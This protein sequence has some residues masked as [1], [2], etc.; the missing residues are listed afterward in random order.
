MRG[1]GRAPQSTRTRREKRAVPWGRVRTDATDAY[2]PL[3]AGANLFGGAHD[4]GTER[5]KT[6]MRSLSGLV[7]QHQGPATKRGF[8]LHDSYESQPLE[9]SGKELGGDGDK[10]RDRYDG[11][12][13]IE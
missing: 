11:E 7:L 4:G 9:P 6:R 5:V 1:G 3:L 8:H 12:T 13:R 10:P 2:V